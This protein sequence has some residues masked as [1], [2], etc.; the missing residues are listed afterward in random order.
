MKAEKDPSDSSNRKPKVPSE[1]YPE[2]SVCNFVSKVPAV[3]SPARQKKNV[4]LE[5]QVLEGKKNQN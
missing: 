5:V 1:R 3:D 4:Q 2:E